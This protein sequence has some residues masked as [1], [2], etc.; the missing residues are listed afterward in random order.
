MTET[1][2]ELAA[3]KR[4]A[5]D[6]LIE[7]HRQGFF[8]GEAPAAGRGYPT[9]QTPWGVAREF[10][11]AMHAADIQRR[12]AWPETQIV[13][14][15]FLEF[16][17]E[18]RVIAMWPIWLRESVQEGEPP[19][20]DVLAINIGEAIQ[21]RAPSRLALQPG[22]FVYCIWEN[23]IDLTDPPAPGNPPPEL[24]NARAETEQIKS[25]WLSTGTQ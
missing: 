8:R 7:R 16:A 21:K 11:P 13:L 22:P 9:I 15:L 20:N 6:R 23:P 2:Q 3:R 14:N 25:R 5:E 18:R 19:Y 10:F 17:P 12:S 1:W 24:V 4:P